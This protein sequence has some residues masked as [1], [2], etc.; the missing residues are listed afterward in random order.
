MQ[1]GCSAQWVIE[2]DGSVYPCDFYA[3]DEW[4][5]GNIHTHSF[6]QLEQ[7]RQ[8]SGFV[9]QSCAVP[10]EC[11]ACPVWALCRNGCRRNR[12]G[13]DGRNYF[14]AAYRGFLEYAIP[15]LQETV[16]LLRVYART[17]KFPSGGDKSEML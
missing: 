6:A 3:L 10:D 15:R 13:E 12:T 4:Y 16:Q 17:G 14:C 2:A 1:G 9:Q 5:L 7:Q 11:K 8:K